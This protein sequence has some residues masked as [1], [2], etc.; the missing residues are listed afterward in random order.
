MRYKNGLGRKISGKSEESP[1]QA[2]MPELN[3]KRLKEVSQIKRNR[4]VLD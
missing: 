4:I 3:F 1:Y 2:M